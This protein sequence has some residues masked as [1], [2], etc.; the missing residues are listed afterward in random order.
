MQYGMQY[1]SK[2]GLNDQHLLPWLLKQVHLLQYF[3]YHRAASQCLECKRFHWALYAV[4]AWYLVFSTALKT[5]ETVGKNVTWV[6]CWE[7]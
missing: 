1:N 4:L 6:N 5:R 7:L 3:Q 2:L